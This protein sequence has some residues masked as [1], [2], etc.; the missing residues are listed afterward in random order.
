ME[1]FEKWV[2][3]IAVVVL[4][5]MLG[6]M[7][8]GGHAV[9]AQGGGMQVDVR[10]IDSGSSLVVYDAGSQTAYVYTQPFVGLPDSYCSYKF[11][12]GAPGG[13]ITR[14]QCNGQ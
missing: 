4:A 7:A 2:G 14:S 3:R 5:L 10:S 9:Q 1:R 8:S 11:K 6:W 12:I 13:K